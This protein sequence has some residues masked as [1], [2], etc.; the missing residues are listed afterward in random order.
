VTDR[1]YSLDGEDYDR[2][3]FFT[4]ASYSW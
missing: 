4:R 1:A 3:Q 2:L